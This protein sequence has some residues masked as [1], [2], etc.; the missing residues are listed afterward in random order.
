MKLS[1]EYLILEV[2]GKGGATFLDGKTNSVIALK[3]FN[4]QSEFER[5]CSIYNF[6]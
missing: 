2:L 6:V 4:I 3:E 5:E 1:K